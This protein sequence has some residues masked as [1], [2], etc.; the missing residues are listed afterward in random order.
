M[1]TIKTNVTMKGLPD[2]YQTL[3]TC[4]ET[5]ILTSGAGILHYA[6]ALRNSPDIALEHISLAYFTGDYTGYIEKFSVNGTIKTNL[7]TIATHL[8][9]DVP[10]FAGKTAAYSGT[11]SASNVMIGDFLRQPL[12]GSISLNEEFSGKSFDPDELQLKIDGTVSEL[13][14]KGYNYHNITTHGTLAKKQ[15][16]GNLLVDDPNLAL[17]F[18]GGI[19][20]AIN[21]PEINAKAHLMASNFKSNH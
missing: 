3:I 7:G 9:M 17:E 12:L 5:E 6:P 15:F 14:F 21:I 4:S 13:G 2:I 16:K 8:K 20:Y 19:N 18:D 10:D 11:V 1:T